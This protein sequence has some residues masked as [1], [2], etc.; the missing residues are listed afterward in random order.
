[1]DLVNWSMMISEPQFE[2]IWSALAIASQ[3]TAIATLKRINFKSLKNYESRIVVI[4]NWNT[5]LTISK[6][7]GSFF[8][9]FPGISLIKTVF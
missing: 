2:L 1:M 7:V 4:A 6:L 3:T 9:F 5:K 8:A